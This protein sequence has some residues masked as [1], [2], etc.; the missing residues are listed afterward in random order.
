M[1]A[2]VTPP[3]R[4]VSETVIFESA[5]GTEMPPY[6]PTYHSACAVVASKDAEVTLAK[7]NLVIHGIR[8]GGYKAV[9]MA[10]AHSEVN[11][12]VHQNASA[13]DFVC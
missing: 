9:C 12:I 13:T 5:P 1:R 7:R 8:V 4:V 6:P 3:P 11:R 10:G 2:L